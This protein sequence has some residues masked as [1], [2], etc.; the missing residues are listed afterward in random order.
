MSINKLNLLLK[1]LKH[2]NQLNR[3][4]YLNRLNRVNALNCLYNLNRWAKG[5]TLS[6]IGVAVILP[7][8]QLQGC[9]VAAVSGAATGVAMV[10]D[11]RTAGTIIDDKTIEIKAMHALTRD[12]ELWKKSHISVI[13]YNN[14]VL[15]VGQTP[16]QAMKQQVEDAIKDI[17]KVKQVYNELK[18]SDPVPL[19][20]RSKDS[21][22]TTQVKAK[23]IGVREINPTRVKVVT[24][25]GIVYL[26]GITN[27]KEQASATETARTV[28]GVNK[29]VQI[30]EST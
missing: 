12:A 7:C 16:T 14:D 1:H 19:S 10:T 8:I 26:L 3:L 15:L 20:T 24:E 4:N 25:D 17:A 5:A 9:A 29:V 11:R 18:L 28:S 30:F 22:I 13:S 27:K 2:L 21:W 23:M 6:L